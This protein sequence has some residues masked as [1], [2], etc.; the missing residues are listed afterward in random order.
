MA[1]LLKNLLGK[2]YSKNTFHLFQIGYPPLYIIFDLKGNIW[3]TI[4][5][6]FVLTLKHWSAEKFA[7]FLNYLPIQGY[8]RA[9]WVGLIHLGCGKMTRSIWDCKVDIMCGVVVVARL[10]MQGCQTSSWL[11][12]SG[13]FVNSAIHC[14]LEIVKVCCWLYRPICPACCPSHCYG[15]GNH[16]K[17]VFPE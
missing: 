10:V 15:G 11:K 8:A 2:M 3:E 6:Q 17:M 1:Q 5:V 16:P 13:F 9:N 14:L 12:W 4:P 7:T